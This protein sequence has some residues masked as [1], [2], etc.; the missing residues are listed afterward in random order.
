MSKKL[1]ITDDA[2]I[3]RAMIREAAEENGW[4]VVAEATNGEEA[5]DLYRRHR[6]ALTTLDLVMPKYDG[7]YA[8]REIRKID[9]EAR[10]VI[11]SA[12]SQKSTLRETLQSGAVDFLVK[13]FAK[14]LLVETLNRAI[15]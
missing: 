9:P 8:L 10:V 4:E 7:L 14:P 2:M 15:S 3:I 11:V 12:L 6:P 1:L 13:P 5:V